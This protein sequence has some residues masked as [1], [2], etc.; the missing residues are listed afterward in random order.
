MP[1]GE[2]RTAY[3]PP[4]MKKAVR[5]NR[6]NPRRHYSSAGAARRGEDGI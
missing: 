5:G 3:K 1:P 4:P 6:A 2:G